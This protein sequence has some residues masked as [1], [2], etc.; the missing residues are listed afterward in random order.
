MI[1][2][3]SDK[4][5]EN[6]LNEKNIKSGLKSLD[7]IQTISNSIF[8]ILRTSIGPRSQSKLIIKS[9]GSYLISNDGSTILRNL[10]M[11]NS[12][13]NVLVQISL[14]Q[15]REIGDG[16]TSVVLITCELLRLLIQY[17]QR[18]SLEQKYHQITLTQVLYEFLTLI[19]TEL[20]PSISMEYQQS[21]DRNNEILYKLAGVALGTKHYSYWTDNLTQLIIDSV[22]FCNNTVS[23]KIDL[24]NSLQIQKLYS[25]NDTIESSEFLRSS[26]IL[27]LSSVPMLLVSNDNQNS[28]RIIIINSKSFFNS[29]N[30]SPIRDLTEMNNYFQRDDRFANEFV[31]V[32]EK[33][34][35]SAVFCRHQI[36]DQLL[37]LLQMNRISVIQNITEDSLEKLERLSSSIGINS[38]NDLSTINIGT[39]TDLELLTKYENEYYLKCT[40]NGDTKSS[41]GVSVIL[42]KGPTKDIV[43]DLE[44]GIIDS[45]YLLKSTLESSSRLVYGG[46]CFEMALAAKLLEYCNGLPLGSLKRDIGEI[47]AETFQVI[48]MLLL[49][50][51]SLDQTSMTPQTILSN[52]IKKHQTTSTKSNDALCSLGIDGW[53][54]DIKDMSTLNIIE[55]LTLKKSIINTSFEA[56]ITFLRIDTYLHFIE[57][58]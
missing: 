31:K 32:I 30:S 1:N 40:N 48:P 52:L 14:S 6:Y 54:G 35:V 38:L 37:Q 33:Y 39:L 34:G 22:E 20:L 53:S 46:G 27:T 57:D 2:N 21:L 26:C 43:D 4:A 55:P 8:S 28:I 42:L 15:D 7:S 36:P 24:R 5:I 11:R 12:I 56:C 17:L 44:I 41:N 18:N 51:S 10:S 49:I 45:L 13:G 16:T 19:D 9:D 3:H 50:N 47:L 25:G 58:E 29:V 23:K